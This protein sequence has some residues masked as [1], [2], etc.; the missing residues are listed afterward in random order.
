MGNS[1]DIGSTFNQSGGCA[2][3]F[4]GRSRG[5]VGTMIA[6]PA[7]YI[8]DSCIDASAAIIREERQKNTHNV[9]TGLPTPKE[10]CGK[11]SEHV[12]GQDEAKEVI[13][14]AVYN[15][16][17]RLK[18]ADK[19]PGFN[20]LVIGKSNI[21]LLGP[22]GTGKTEIARSIARYL[23]VP[24]AQADATALTEAGYVGE[25]V[26]SMV[27]K[28]LQSADGDIQKAQRGII[29]IDEIDKIARK[30]ANG[31]ITRD[32]SGE[33]VQQAL[34]KIIEG[35]VC[36]VPPQGGRK[37][38]GQEMIAV[39]TTNILFI[40][41]GA[42]AG[43]DEVIKARQERQKG[44][45]SIGFGA[46]V[47][48]KDTD[49]RNTGEVMKDVTPTDLHNFGIIPELVGRLPVITSTESLSRETLVRILS[50]PKDAL[51][52]QYASLFS[53]DG[54]KLTF[55][56]DALE[57]IADKAIALNTGARGL[58]SIVEKALKKT[59]FE[60]PGQTNVKE[61]VV[62]AEVVNDNKSPLYITHE[63]KSKAAAPAPRAL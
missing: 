33:G 4:C 30:S 15:H 11:L 29:Y 14:T 36:N 22:T 50:E 10:I 6:G 5:E 17:K 51:T 40:C 48:E 43:I 34:L 35:T 13:S 59:M 26:E 58:R 49:R 38:P 47:R 19:N 12:I 31:S 56:Q 2:C 46:A 16:Y 28:L 7:S 20:D 63:K 37:H 25:D 3:S 21:L 57:A 45:T 27:L 60:L 18:H 62:T 61:V 52:K 42:F 39:D 24:F 41:A 9:A 1:N 53:M 8:C 23:D 32:V 44:S 55:R 54:H